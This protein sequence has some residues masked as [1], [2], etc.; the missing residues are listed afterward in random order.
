MLRIGRMKMCARSAAGA[1]VV[2][3]IVKCSHDSCFVVCILMGN[4][5]WLR[6]CALAFGKAF[7]LQ[8]HA[9]VLDRRIRPEG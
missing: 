3:E 5:F 9:R 7:R 8:E 4:G 6:V 1:M 2:L